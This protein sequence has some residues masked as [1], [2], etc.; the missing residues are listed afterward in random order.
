MKI[1]VGIPVR[2]GSTRFPGKPLCNILGKPM[3]EHVYK[4]SKLSDKATEV[5]AAACDKEIKDVVENFGGKVYM[6]PKEISRPC[7][8]VAEACKQMDLDDDDVVVVVQGD[9]PMVHP[10]MIDLAVEAFLKEKD[11][12]CVNLAADMTEEEWNDPNEIKV[13][14]DLNMNAIYMSRNPIPSNT[15]NRIG[16]RIKQV[17]IMPFTKKSLLYYQSLPPTPLEIAESI[18]LLRA[19]EHGQKIHIV[20]TDFINKSVDTESDRKAVEELMKKDEIYKK[21]GY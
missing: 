16:P 3:I 10:K 1:V 5:F 21:Y 19:L 11:A 2:M 8:R 13:V 7:L 17:C 6:T 9:E 12:L 18:E 14:T 4:R 15:R 20:K